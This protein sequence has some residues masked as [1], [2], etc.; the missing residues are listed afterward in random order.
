[1]NLKI[2]NQKNH[3]SIELGKTIQLQTENE[4]LKGENQKLAAQLQD[5]FK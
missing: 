5:A 4:N 2:D 3:L 1:M